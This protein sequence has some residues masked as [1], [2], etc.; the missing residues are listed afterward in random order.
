MGSSGRTAA[1]M[2]SR[3][4]STDQIG[5]LKCLHLLGDETAE[6][7][8]EV[9]AQVLTFA[10]ESDNGAEIVAPVAGVIAAALE[11]DTVHGATDLLVRGE[12]LQG[13]GE[14]D[15]AAAPG[16]VLR[17]MSKTAGSRT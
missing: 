15:L 1:R 10:R 3:C 2:S 6:P 11:D 8:P 14:L 4:S 7:A 13:V 16:S 5:L 12:Q 9:R 17:S